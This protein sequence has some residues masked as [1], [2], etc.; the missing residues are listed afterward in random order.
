MAKI[1]L[2]A[3]LVKFQ[4]TARDFRI[5]EHEQTNFSGHEDELAPLKK[6]ITGEISK[7]SFCRA[8]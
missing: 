7:E 6:F 4:K 8:N 2:N 1:G 5:V 3:L